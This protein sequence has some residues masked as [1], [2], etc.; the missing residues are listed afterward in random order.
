MPLLEEAPGFTSLGCTQ[1]SSA[2]AV[3]GL[4]CAF[5]DFPREVLGSSSAISTWQLVGGW[6]LDPK[7]L[8]LEGTDVPHLQPA[9]GHQKHLPPHAGFGVGDHLLGCLCTAIGREVGGFRRP[10]LVSGEE[11]VSQRLPTAWH[12]AGPA[13]IPQPR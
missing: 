9:T 8:F 3:R 5:T 13:G 12:A 4:C 7:R 6:G 2:W 10:E 1:L 11:I